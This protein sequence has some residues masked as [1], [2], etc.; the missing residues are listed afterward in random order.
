MDLIGVLLLGTVAALATMSVTGTNVG[1]SGL[2]LLIEK[3]PDSSGFVLFLAGLAAVFL[4][5][6]SLMTL[7]LT[8][9]IFRFLANRQALVAG[10]LAQRLLNRPLLEVQSRSSQEISIALT[11][12]VSALTI[13]TLGQ[14]VVVVSE[15]SLTIALIVGLLFVDPI[16]AIFSLC[17]FGILVVVLQLLMGSWA[18]S[19]GNRF[20]IADIRS[21]AAMQHSLRAYREI[22]VSGRRQ[23]FIDKFQ[24]AR[25]EAARIQSDTY[26]VHQ[27]GK[28]VFEIGLIVGGGILIAIVAASN[29]LTAG[30][31][32]ITVFLAASA[33]IFPSLLRLQGALISIRSAE[34]ASAITLNLISDLDSAQSTTDL[35]SN[36]LARQV[37]KQTEL[38]YLGYPDFHPSISV[39]D[40]TL[41]YPGA[42][43]KSL[44]HVSIDIPANQSVALVGL[45]GAGKSTLADVILG[46][47]LPDSGEV[48]ISGKPPHEAVSNWPGAITYVPQDVAVLSGSIR[49]NVALGIVDDAID[50]ELVWQALDRAHLSQFLVESREGLE[51]LVGENG[52]QLSGGQRQRL[53]IARALYSRPR[54]LVMDEATSAL[55]SE[56][57][58]LI[59]E[60]LSEISRNTTIIV[61][62]HRLA[63]VRNFDKVIYLDDG[64]VAGIGT[65]AEVRVQVPNLDRQA[66]LLGL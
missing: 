53:G 20:M 13:N 58:T 16:V 19:L 54:L 11:S 56:T 10:N 28:Y 57:E 3:I 65:F 49:E 55:D 29:N 35:H 45:S 1:P 22:S 9:K 18:T 14:A 44:D 21:Y 23:M 8:R 6:K 64:K 40:V 25:W 4:I 47:L 66:R 7:L 41:T 60:T 27:V 5:G 48:R 34:G 24:K 15:I 30:I 51:T 2:G 32:I 46:V 39:T 17:F 42:S 59:T 31:A 37:T 62:A 33:R 26:I 52:V 43:N 63:T 36:L 12:G 38:A 61:I 50:D